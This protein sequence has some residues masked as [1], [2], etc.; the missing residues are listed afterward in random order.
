[1]LLLAGA[2]LAASPEPACA[3][4][5]AYSTDAEFLANSDTVFVGV[6]TAIEPD[7]QSDTEAHRVSFRVESVVKGDVGATV[8]LRALSGGDGSCGYEFLRDNRYRV[9]A[10]IGQTNLCSGNQWLGAAAEGEGGPVRG[11]LPMIWL[12]PG[13]VLVAAAAVLLFVRMPARRGRSAAGGSGTGD[14]QLSA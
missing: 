10:A 2:G 6:V 4:S 13:A 1:M 12:I 9:N 11:R 3:C 14:G 5:C 7:R 8:T